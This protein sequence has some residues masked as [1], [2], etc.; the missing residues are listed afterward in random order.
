MVSRILLRL[1]DEAVLPAVV[2]LVA[3]ILA[4]VSLIYFLKLDWQFNT[5]SL[6]PEI[7]FESSETVTFVNSYSNLFLYLVILLGLGW[8]LVRAYHLHD[9]HIAPSFVLQLLSW[10]L[11]GLLSSSDEVYHQGF[12]WFSY[13][14]LVT[15]LIGLN[16]FLGLNYLWI[17]IFAIACS[18]FASWVLVADVEREIGSG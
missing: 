7:L 8:V 2:V 5:T 18:L 15:L 12:I 4:V 13:L 14:W 9:T 1:I 17:F 3:K 16:T 11:T 10:N 6:I